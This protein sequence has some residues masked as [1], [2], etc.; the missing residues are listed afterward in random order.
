MDIKLG[1]GKQQGDS[2]VIFKVELILRSE[3]EG[4]WCFLGI[5]VC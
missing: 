2:G 5:P 3:M 1:Y 4:E